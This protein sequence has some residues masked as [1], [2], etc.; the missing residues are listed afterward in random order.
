MVHIPWN[1]GGDKNCVATT[2]PKHAK[3]CMS[4]NEVV[5]GN[6]LTINVSML[7]GVNQLAEPYSLSHPS[8]GIQ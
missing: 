4:V 2:W 1:I 5:F 3:L 6:E 8:L 7:F